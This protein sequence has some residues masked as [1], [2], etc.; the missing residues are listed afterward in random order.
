MKL[1]FRSRS[2]GASQHLQASCALIVP[3]QSSGLKLPHAKYN[4]S[5]PAWALVRST[6]DSPSLSYHRNI[7]EFA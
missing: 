6:T 3:H 7:I 4:R 1:P 5:T 2:L